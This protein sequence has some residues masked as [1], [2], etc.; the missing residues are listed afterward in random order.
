MFPDGIDLKKSKLTKDQRLWIVDALKAKRESSYSLA[1]KLN[2][3]SAFIRTIRLRAKRPKTSRPGRPYSLDDISRGELKA[4]KDGGDITYEAVIALLN[5]EY[6]ATRQRR[7]SDNRVNERKR[8][9]KRMSR[10]TRR[11]YIME[12]FPELLTPTV[13]LS[14]PSPP[15]ISIPISN[16]GDAGTRSSIGSIVNVI[17]STIFPSE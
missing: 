14:Q 15:T 17:Y 11:R 12:Y 13:A 4:F 6:V 7:H 16:P 1:R 3:K 9:R 10:G 8:K 5:R 2:C